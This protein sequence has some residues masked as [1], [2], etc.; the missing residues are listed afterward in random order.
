VADYWAF[1]HQCWILL[2]ISNDFK[3]K[4]PNK[5]LANIPFDGEPPEMSSL[6]YTWVLTK[7]SALFNT[8]KEMLRL[9]EESGV[10]L[11]LIS[12]YSA[13]TPISKY[14]PAI[15]LATPIHTAVTATGRSKR[16]R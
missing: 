15:A 1:F 13:V 12:D 9:T 2:G 7:Q 14:T 6:E 4:Y 11:R 10:G 3:L 16:T 5:Y 8:W